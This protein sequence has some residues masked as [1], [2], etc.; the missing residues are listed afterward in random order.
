MSYNGQFTRMTPTRL[1]LTQLF[2]WVESVS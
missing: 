2:S 1:N